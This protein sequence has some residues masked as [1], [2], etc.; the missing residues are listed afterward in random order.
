[1]GTLIGSL[2]DYPVEIDHQIDLIFTRPVN[3]DTGQDLHI[4][5][6]N[7]DIHSAFEACKVIVTE[8]SEGILGEPPMWDGQTHHIR[9]AWRGVRW[10]FRRHADTGAVSV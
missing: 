7:C 5:N 10:Q 8:C 2:W 4:D 1:M 6:V 9:H 3:F